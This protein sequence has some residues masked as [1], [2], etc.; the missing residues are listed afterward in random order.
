M[1]GTAVTT[2][3][4]VHHV[5]EQVQTGLTQLLTAEYWK[6][7]GP[8]LLDAAR[9]VERLAHLTYAIQVTLAGE[10]DLAHLAQSHG[11]PST[12]A[13]LR[14]A[15]TISPGDAR[16]RVRA[17]QAVLPRTPSAAAKSHPDT[18]NSAPPC[19]PAPWAANT[20]ASCSPP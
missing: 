13:L 9:T 19:A 16:G 14:H 8:D 5:A 20:P 3:D 6:L 18:P 7:P 4:D 12:A 10:A 1:A 2:L 17:A 11:Q 15:L